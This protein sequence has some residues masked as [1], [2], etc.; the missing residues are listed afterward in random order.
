MRGQM[1]DEKTL[2]DQADKIRLTKGLLAAKVS[3]GQSAAM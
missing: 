1:P 3:E 2:L